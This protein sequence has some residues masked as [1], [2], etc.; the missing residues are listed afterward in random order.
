[1]GLLKLTITWD[2][3][4]SITISF[5]SDSDEAKLEQITVKEFKE[6]VKE[7]HAIEKIIDSKIYFNGQELQDH[8]VMFDKGV[9]N[10]SHLMAILEAK[11]RRELKVIY[12]EKQL[13]V[14]VYIDGY[15][16]DLKKAI[17]ESLGIPQSIQ[18]IKVDG[19]VLT[20]DY[21]KDKYNIDKEFELVSLAEVNIKAGSAIHLELT[22]P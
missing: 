19:E 17:A 14:K 22:K 16:K 6:K 7:M 10:E 2:S 5:S 13:T 20:S 12:K 18:K 9:A 3:N 21:I 1:M 8:D 15:I 11:E 4:R